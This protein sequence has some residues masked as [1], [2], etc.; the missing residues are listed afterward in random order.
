MKAAAARS[1]SF[2]DTNAKNALGPPHDR[3]PDSAAPSPKKTSNPARQIS[4]KLNTFCLVAWQ[5][6]VKR[7]HGNMKPRRGEEAWTCLTEDEPNA[8]P[9]NL[10]ANRRR[11]PSVRQHTVIVQQQKVIVQQHTVKANSET[12]TSP[13]FSAAMTCMCTWCV[14]TKRSPELRMHHLRETARLCRRGASS[15]SRTD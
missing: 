15:I 11:L 6:D 10:R 12:M 14:N 5:A 9:S 4:G 8:H 1:R 13:P 3:P 7:A 2:S